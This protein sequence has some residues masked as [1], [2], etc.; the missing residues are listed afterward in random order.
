MTFSGYILSRT[1]MSGGF[2]TCVGMKIGE[3]W[4]QRRLQR[5]HGGPLDFRQLPQR[6]AWLQANWTVGRIVQFREV[7]TGTTPR[8][9]HPEDLWV[10]PTSVQLMNSVGDRAGLLR[11]IDKFTFDDIAALYPAIRT[12]YDRY[13]PAEPH[14]RSVGYVRRVQGRIYAQQKFGKRSLRAY[15]SDASGL[16]LGNVPVNGVELIERLQGLPPGGNYVFANATARFSLANPW[17]PDD[18]PEDVALKC[19]IQ[20]S[21]IV[22]P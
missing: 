15:L 14:P 5:P 16:S 9:T 20:V 8:S 7:S 18:A 6:Y 17:R 3:E 4:V 19:Y 22:T 12:T 11:L 1:Q 21:D 2:C 10:D 13:L